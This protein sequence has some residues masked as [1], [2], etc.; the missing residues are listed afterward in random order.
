MSKPDR[1][2]RIRRGEELLAQRNAGASAE[3]LGREVGR[4]ADADLA[5]A[6]RLGGIA[7]D[8]SAAIL[9]Q[10]E[11]GAAD[12]AVR[13]EAK[14]SLYKLEQQGVQI[15]RPVQEPRKLAPETAAI[16]GYLSTIDGRGDQ[17]VWL[18]RPRA[19][20]L[21]H[22]FAVVNDPEGMKDLNLAEV[23]RKGL[24]SLREELMEKHEIRVIDADWHYCDFLIDRSSRWAA[25]RGQA[26]GDYPRLRAQLT[27]EP[28]T[29]MEPL[30]FRHLDRSAIESDTTLVE[31]SATVLDEKEFRT[32]FLERDVLAPYLDRLHEVRDSPLVLNEAQQGERFASVADEAVRALFGGELREAWVRRL[33]EMAYFFHATSRPEQARK[34]LAAALALASSENGGKDVPLCDQLCRTSLLAYW[35]LEERQE[36]EEK[37]SS[38]VVTP[39]QAAKEAEA[40][41][42]S[43]R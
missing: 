35:Q 14:R 31:Q 21:L 19:G 4:D 16:E 30:I 20:A 33:Q 42:R 41:R 39:Q 32:W 37:A 36:Q 18:T 12:K 22:L 5:I 28:V 25:E 10:L 24:R 17:L 34:T 40:R 26:A 3:D 23:S 15:E 7:D 1:D 27:A 6:A 9:R 43:G 2:K 13:K 38:L 11:D 29:E 8:A